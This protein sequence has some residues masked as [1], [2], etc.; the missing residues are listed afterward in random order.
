META[1]DIVM[2]HIF[3]KVTCEEVNDGLLPRQSI[4]QEKLYWGISTNK[5]S[6]EGGNKRRRFIPDPLELVYDSLNKH[7]M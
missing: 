4:F 1:K 3:V 2:K 6:A 5:E 7:I